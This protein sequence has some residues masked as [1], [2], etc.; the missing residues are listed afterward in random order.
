MFARIKLKKVW[1]LDRG[2][3]LVVATGATPATGAIVNRLVGFGIGGD[4][5]EC[6]LVA[7]RRRLRNV[8]PSTGLVD[9]LEDGCR[10]DWRA[11]ELRSGPSSGLRSLVF[12]SFVF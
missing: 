4:R 3:G 5:R 12:W 10:V 2:I 8:N 6:P 7:D 11:F 9:V 1:F